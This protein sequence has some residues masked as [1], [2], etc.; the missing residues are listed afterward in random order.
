MPARATAGDR[1]LTASSAWLWSETACIQNLSRVGP[2]TRPPND[3]SVPYGHEEPRTDRWPPA[4]SAPD[5]THRRPGIP[6]LA[7]WN[8]EPASSRQREVIHRTRSLYH[9]Q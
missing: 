1:H 3:P 8:A 9:R 6:L 4:A 2:T 7:V 5:V